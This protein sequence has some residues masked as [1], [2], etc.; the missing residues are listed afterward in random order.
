MRVGQGGSQ[1]LVTLQGHKG[2]C[3]PRVWLET[4]ESFIHVPEPY[5]DSSGVHVK[6]VKEHETS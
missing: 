4:L 5:S 6:E 1:A 3:G 2:S